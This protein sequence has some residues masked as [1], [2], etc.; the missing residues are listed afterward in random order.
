MLVK[1]VQRYIPFKIFEGLI[2]IKSQVRTFV[3]IKIKNKI[4][5]KTLIIIN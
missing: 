5:Q 2:A 3:E 1:K 4:K